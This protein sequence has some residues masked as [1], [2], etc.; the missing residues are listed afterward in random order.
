MRQIF[1][2]IMIFDS[3]KK[4]DIAKTQTQT[5]PSQWHV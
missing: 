5:N 1:D 3:I 4:D 2:N